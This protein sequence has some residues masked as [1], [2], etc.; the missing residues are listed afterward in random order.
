MVILL[1]LSTSQECMA[2][3]QVQVTDKER[4]V[5]HLAKNTPLPSPTKNQEREIQITQRNDKLPPQK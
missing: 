5:I 3:N 2:R 1:Q 4:R